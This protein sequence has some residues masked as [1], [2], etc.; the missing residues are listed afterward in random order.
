MRVLAAVALASAAAFAATAQPLSAP[1]RAAVISADEWHAGCPTPLSQ[2][3]LLT[4]RYLGFD[5]RAH[6][7]QL[8]VNQAAVAP[9]EKVFARLYALRFPIR[10][11]A[12]SDTYGPASGQPADGDVTASFECRQASASPCGGLANNTTGTWS[13][14]A[15]GEAVDLNPVEN[16]YVGCGMTRDRT[17]LSYLDRSR[18]RK[19]MVTPAVVAAFESAGWGWGGSWTGSTKDYMHF[20]AT[21]H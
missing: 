11:M 21:G 5:D 2:L 8:V 10:H 19:G 6:S 9:L 17:A 20:S 4:V 18:V 1:V 7:G 16:P 13:E 14:H 12:L 15:Y 3:R